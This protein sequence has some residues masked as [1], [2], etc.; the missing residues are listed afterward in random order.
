MKHFTVLM[1]MGVSAIF[2]DSYQTNDC[3]VNSET[4]SIAPHASLDPHP[5]LLYPVSYEMNYF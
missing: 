4:E 2:E 5:L 3:P 1:N